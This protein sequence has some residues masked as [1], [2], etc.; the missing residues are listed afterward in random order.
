MFG[1][2]ST[3]REVQ[4][5]MRSLGGSSWRDEE[6]QDESSLPEIPD[7][8][9]ADMKSI[10]AFNKLYSAETLSKLVEEKLMAPY[11]VKVPSR[12]SGL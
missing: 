1:Y 6:E 4:G 9:E 12:V 3:E 2:D 7:E 5:M 10:E 8:E 11:D